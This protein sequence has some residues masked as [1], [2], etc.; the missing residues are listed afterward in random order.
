MRRANQLQ[1]Q[2]NAISSGLMARATQ[3][4][5]PFLVAVPSGGGGSLGGAGDYGLTIQNQGGGLAHDITVESNWGNAQLPS[6]GQGE[7]AE[8][9][10][11]V[12]E[13]YDPSHAIEVSRFR[14]VDPAG[15]EWIQ[16]PSQLPI[17]AET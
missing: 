10:F 7:R 14:F 9:T 12:S 5:A 13:G 8:L 11:H 16:A 15:T 2:A 4:D 3:Q 1:E 6:L 17:R